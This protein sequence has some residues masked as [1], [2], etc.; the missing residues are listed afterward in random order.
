MRSGDGSQ[1]K[2]GKPDWAAKLGARY[3]EQLK[4]FALEAGTTV[5]I[6]AAGM[7]AADVP[8]LSIV[9]QGSGG[10]LLLHQSKP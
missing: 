7:A 1:G 4:R 5:D 8:L 10:V 2:A 6:M 9:A 3:F